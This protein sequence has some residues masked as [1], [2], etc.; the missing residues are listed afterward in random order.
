MKKNTNLADIGERLKKQRKE[1]NIRQKE[2]AE[3]LGIAPTYLSEI[4]NGKG[5]PGPDIFVKLA[6]IY[7]INLHY[8]FMGDEDTPVKKERRPDVSSI[9]LS[10]ELDS[11][12]KLVLLM[13][14]SAYIRNSVMAWAAK[15]ILE[16]KEFIET[17]LDKKPIKK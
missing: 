14:N 7:G 16:N 8:L 11:I 10:A 4:E 17:V 3:A 5:N 1:M 12:D 15:F 6:S 9:D 2:M 13:E